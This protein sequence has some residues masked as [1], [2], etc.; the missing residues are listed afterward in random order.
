ML[1]GMSQVLQS[2]QFSRA[3]LQIMPPKLILAVTRASPTRIPITTGIAGSPRPVALKAEPIA[4][5][6]DA[7]PNPLAAAAHSIS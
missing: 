4:L 7:R 5:Y 1:N 2:I 6:A 3:G